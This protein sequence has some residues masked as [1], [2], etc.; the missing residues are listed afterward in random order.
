MVLVLWLRTHM[1]FA[2]AQLLDGQL[3]FWLLPILLQRW[4]WGWS[5]LERRLD[6]SLCKFVIFNSMT[7]RVHSCGL[8]RKLSLWNVCQCGLL[9]TNFWMGC[10]LSKFWSIECNYLALHAICDWSWRSHK[11]QR[12]SCHLCMYCYYYPRSFRSDLNLCMCRTRMSQK[13]FRRWQQHM[14][15]KLQRVCWATKWSSL[16]CKQSNFECNEPRDT[17]R[18]CWVWGE[19]GVCNWYCY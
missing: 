17:S 2:K 19:R 3:T 8:I 10:F 12:L 14:T 4:P 15:A 16:W 1:C 5:G 11:L 9:V 13:L 7:S 18:W 6:L